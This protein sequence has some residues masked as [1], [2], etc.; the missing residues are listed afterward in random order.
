MLLADPTMPDL[1]R[2]ATGHEAP[3]F[4]RAIGDRM[5]GPV[6]RIIQTDMRLRTDRRFA[7]IAL[8]IALWRGDHAGALPPTLDALVPT[9][10]PA[11][12]LD[13]S[14]VNRPIQFRT[15]PAAR[16]DGGARPV[17]YSVGDDGEDD[18]ANNGQLPPSMLLQY[19]WNSTRPPLDDQYRDLERWAAPAPATAPASE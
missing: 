17:L 5:V 7:A 9:Y 19:G 16:P 10:L 4:S 11:V 14:A 1:N 2:S 3:R 6:D 8:A 18:T 13:P 12:P 15:F